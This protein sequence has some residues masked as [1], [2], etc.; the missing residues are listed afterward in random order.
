VTNPPARGSEPSAPD[1]IRRRSWKAILLGLLGIGLI[2]TVFPYGT[3]LGL[4]CAVAALVTGIRTR[5]T[6]R[7]AKVP[8][9]RA[10]LGVVSGSIGL[11]LGLAVTISLAM[12]WTEFRT[13]TECRDNSLTVQ[14]KDACYTDLI[15]SLEK[16][17]GV[18]S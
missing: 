16:R 11:V 10:T 12:F 13:Y 9:A 5:R 8:T 1:V 18:R 7:K 17:V 14:A 4:V 3:V 2:G 15:H 6:A